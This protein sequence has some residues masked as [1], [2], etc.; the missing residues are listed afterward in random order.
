MGKVIGGMAVSLDGFIHDRE[1]SVARLYADMDA[2]METALMQ[3]AMQN[4][5]AVVMGRHTYEM[6]NS[7]FTGYEF[8]V[9]I[10]VLTHHAPEK[11]AKGENDKLKFHFI[12][13]GIDSA[14]EQAKAA[15]GIRDV[16]VVG[17]AN[18]FQQCLKAGILDEIQITIVPVLLG[19][20]LR[21]FEPFDAEQIELETIN[22]ITSSSGRT[23]MILRVVK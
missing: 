8:Q 7:D 4:T 18:T 13:A 21:L 20:G 19:D 6:G 23:D 15:A 16:M 2:M 10:F 3:D 1:G 9:P 11:A 14:F 22:V 5:G 17:G 12:S